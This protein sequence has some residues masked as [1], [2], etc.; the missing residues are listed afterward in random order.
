MKVYL[1]TICKTLVVAIWL[2]LI[3]T[4]A[5]IYEYPVVRFTLVDV[6]GQSYSDFIDE[7]RSHLVTGDDVR[8]G[9]PVLRS[10]VDIA[11]RFVLVE[12]T[13]LQGV[14]ITVAVD[15]INV[16]VVGYRAGNRNPI[17]FRPDNEADSVA[18]TH[19]FPGTD[20]QTLTNGGNYDDLEH[21]AGDRSGIN[22]G[23]HALDAAI[24]AL[25]DF[26][27]GGHGEVPLD[28]LLRSFMVG[29]QMISEA[30]RF[31]LIRDDIG[32]RID[33]NQERPPDPRILSDNVP[34]N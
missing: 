8:H 13:N 30:A 16:Y 17:F 23:L 31:N 12:L 29:I 19:V 18:I 9:I 3:T 11:Q 27:M 14:T 4:T 24:S 7:L 22:L 28:R 1:L 6:T 26:A 25:Y 15:V 2:G 34:R 33:E 20:G 10:T 21:H 32:V 5:A